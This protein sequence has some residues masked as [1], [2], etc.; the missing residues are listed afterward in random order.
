[1]F[2][3]P[4]GSQAGTP[5]LSALQSA[6]GDGQASAAGATLSQVLW[7]AGETPALSALQSAF[8]DGQAALRGRL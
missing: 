4:L 7:V 1:M 6:F 8:G 2:T 3:L 5:A